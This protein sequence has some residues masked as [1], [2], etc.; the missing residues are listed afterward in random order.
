MVSER[1]ALYRRQRARY[2]ARRRRRHQPRI[3][4]RGRDREF[5]SGKIKSRTGIG[6]RLGAGAKAPRMAGKLDSG[7]ADIRS[8]E[9][10]NGTRVRKRRFTANFTQ[11]VSMVSRLA[12][13][14]STVHRHRAATRTHSFAGSR[15][16][17]PPG[18]ARRWLED[19]KIFFDALAFQKVAVL[20]P[21]G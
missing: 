12:F 1:I 3:A 5:T 14:S 18:K 9:G 13:A 8:S 11:T 21:G 20:Q 10:G 16:T 19:P 4:G 6:G 7:D 2:V 17:P 15:I